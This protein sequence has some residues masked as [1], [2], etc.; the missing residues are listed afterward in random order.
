VADAVSPAYLTSSFAESLSASTMAGLRNIATGGKLS[1]TGFDRYRQAARLWRGGFATEIKGVY[2][3]PRGLPKVIVRGTQA[4]KAKLG[5]KTHLTHAG[6]DYGSYVTRMARPSVLGEFAWALRAPEFWAVN[7]VLGVGLNV[8]DYGWG[9]KADVGIG[10]PEFYAAVTVDL[11]LNVAAAG[12][13]A[14]T[15]HFAFAIAM[16]IAP[17]FAVPALV[18]GYII[19]PI[20]FAGASHHFGWRESSVRGVTA[21]T[22]T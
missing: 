4:L 22:T 13:G 7:I 10:S 17:E 6:I 20:L 21:S 11:G 14:L 16:V 12:A 1:Y 9:S 2:P 15:A 18:V 5:L 8:L 3:G 19:G